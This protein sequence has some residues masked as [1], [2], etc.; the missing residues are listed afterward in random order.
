MK[1]MTLS[2]ANGPGSDA[3]RLANGSRIDPDKI[4]VGMFQN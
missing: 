4:H 2:Y 3:N 1:Y